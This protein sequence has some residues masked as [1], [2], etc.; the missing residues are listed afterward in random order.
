MHAMEDDAGKYGFG[1]RPDMLPFV[2]MR[3]RLL[4]VGCASGGF[5][6]TLRHAGFTD[7]MWGIEPDP[8]AAARAVDQFDEVITGFYPDHL[9]DGERFDTV[10]F[11]DVLEHLVDPWEALRTTEQVLAPGG[12]VV[13]SIPNIRYWPVLKELAFRGKWTYTETGT[14]DRTHL[15]FF[16]RETIADMFAD[17]GYT[18][19]RLE[20]TNV[21]STQHWRARYVNLLPVDL[22]ALQYAVVARLA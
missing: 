22:R 21:L 6:H 2:P 9:P 12:V 3:G 14:L 17:A 8:E 11:N 10:V 7:E 13:A 20:P 16:T 4:E 15:R 1:T 19:D 5:A 18:V